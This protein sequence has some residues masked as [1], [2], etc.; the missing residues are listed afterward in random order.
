MTTIVIS[1]SM[2]FPWVGLLNQVKLADIYVHYDDVQL[3]RG[4]YNRV[5][6][7]IDGKPKFLTVPIQDK[8][9]NQRIDFSRISYNEQWREKQR[10]SLKVT[11]QNALYGEEALAIFDRV[12]DRQYEFLHQLNRASISAL[13]DYC[14]LTEN[15]SVKCSTQLST[16]G[17]GSERLLHICK[18]LGAKN[19]LTGHGALNYLNHELFEKNSIDV[20]YVKYRFEPYER[21]PGNYTPYVTALDAI[22]HLGPHLKKS[23]KSEI[24][25]WR[26]AIEQPESLR[27]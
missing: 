9:Q 8:R 1:Q 21:K 27:A 25:N 10:E 24:V 17:H 15:T 3:T 14:Q 23:L 26:K 12:H 22:A 18:Q 2:Y 5:Q 11:L 20:Y 7:N 13:N 4:F 19:Y 16:Q 6:I